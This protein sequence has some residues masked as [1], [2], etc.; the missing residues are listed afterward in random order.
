MI[1]AILARV[2][3]VLDRRATLKHLAHFYRNQSAGSSTGESKRI[4]IYAGIGH[5]YITCFEILLYHLLSKKGCTVDYI[6]YD[7]KIPINELITKDVIKKVGKD[8]FWNREVRIAKRILTY[9]KVNFQ[10]ID[11][12]ADAVLHDVNSNSSSLE[13]IYAFEKNGIAIGD[14]V[15]GSMFRYYKSL[16]FDDNAL[17]VARKFM[18][19][20]L[21]NLN[22]I[23]KRCTESTYDTVLFSHGIYSTWEP[24]ANYCRNNNIDFVAYDRAKTRNTINMNFNQ[25]APDWSFDSAWKRYEQR[26]LTPDEDNLVTE[27]LEERE[28]HANDVYAYNFSERSGDIAQ[29]K[30]SLKIPAGKTVIT[31]FTNLIWDAANVSRDLAFENA[32]D[33]VTSTIENYLKSDNVHVV[34][35]AH[36]AEKVLGTKERYGDLVREHFKN[37]LPSS[38]TIIEPEMSINSFS[39]IDI[40]DIGIVNT[41]TVGLEFA[42][43]GKPIILI[44]DTH[45]RDKGFT[46]DVNSRE[47]YFE[48][49]DDLVEQPTLKPNQVKL[50]RKYFYMMMFKY[51]HITPINYKN[52]F[53]SNYDYKDFDEA[54][55]ND[56]KVNLIASKIV[57]TATDD[58]ILWD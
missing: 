14:I 30:E 58:F 44:S 15:K 50:A 38:L 52:G 43:L 29:L 48:C 55:K 11:A 42:L 21:T 56:R 20:A 40:S 31:I 16:T 9:S 6:I 33:C 7:E 46:Y 47:E 34:L 45:Y 13:E 28:L 22:E 32:L 41:S 5:M 19:T 8:K 18:H 17:Q 53:F 57:G 23:E 51:Q 49:L 3:T 12:Q 35:R 10:F 25:P 4:L 27:Y 36:P 24:V 1:K 39:V 26:S 37:D 54:V 2:K